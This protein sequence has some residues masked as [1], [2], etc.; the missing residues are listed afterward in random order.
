MLPLEEREGGGIIECGKGVREVVIGC[1][2]AKDRR[3][4]DG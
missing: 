2:R 4:T 3:S 1:N